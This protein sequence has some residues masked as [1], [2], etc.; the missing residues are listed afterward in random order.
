MS[1]QNHSPTKTETNKNI[2]NRILIL[3][4]FS[5]EMGS[6]CSCTHWMT[7]GTIV[8]CSRNLQCIDWLMIHVHNN[9]TATLCHWW[10]CVCVWIDS[11]E[12]KLWPRSGGSLLLRSF[13]FKTATECA[14]TTSSANK[15]YFLLITWSDCE[16]TATSLCCCAPPRT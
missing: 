11:I 3:I 1:L 4:S 9:Y 12:C 5:L 14:K 15:I 13:N 6:T 8:E 7:F 10:V 2:Q 16:S